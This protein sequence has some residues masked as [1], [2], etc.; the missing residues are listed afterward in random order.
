MKRGFQLVD[1]FAEQPLLGNPVAVVAAARG[2]TSGEMQQFTRWIN[3][4][5][6]TFLLPPDSKEADYK[7]RIFTLEREMPFAGH[8][9]LGTCHAW[10]RA[11]GVPRHADRIVQECGAGLVSVRR[12]AG[13][14]SFAAPQL[15]KTG[16]VDERDLEAALR[17]LRIGRADIVDAQWVDNG[18]GWLGILLEDASAV[19]D[20][21]PVS[22][23]ETRCDIGVVGPY[24]RASEFAFELRAFFT[25]HQ[26]VVREDPV[27]GSLNASV[28]QWLLAT[29][30]C[31]A[32]YVASQGQRLGRAGR[33]HI[34][35]DDDG[36]VWV[37]G[38]TI[39]I[40]DGEIDI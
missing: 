36:T 29:K 1:V 4:S 15:V 40:V 14:L 30:R 12:D 19:I 18:P 3:L 6:S 24:P 21:N 2:L 33:I 13:R 16:P 25:D 22:N 7:V 31:S 39:T 26:G 9:T 27:T 34:D 8:P 23:S 32:P 5:E 37:G 10:L 38:T 20:L 17:A 35:E 28:A 11:G